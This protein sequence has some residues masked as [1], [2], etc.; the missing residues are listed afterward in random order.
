MVRKKC[1]GTNATVLLDMLVDGLGGNAKKPSRDNPR[2]AT[3]N[4]QC[5]VNLGLVYSP[6]LAPYR[7]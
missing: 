2:L 6:S 5:K 4:Q 3:L 7:V 1:P